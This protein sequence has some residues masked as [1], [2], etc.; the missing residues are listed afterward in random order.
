MISGERQKVM[1]KAAKW[2]CGLEGLVIIQYGVLV[3]RSGYTRQ[4]SGIKGIISKVMKSFICR[5]GDCLNPVTS[6]GAGI[7]SATDSLSADTAEHIGMV[8]VAENFRTAGVTEQ[9]TTMVR[10]VRTLGHAG[11]HES[12]AASTTHYSSVTTI[13]G[14]TGA[15]VHS[16]GHNLTSSSHTGR[17]GSSQQ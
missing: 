13:R 5:P 15:C 11:H 8:S 9:Q 14:H 10:V 6:T 4:C 3:V 17:P 1:Q 2:P 7:G 12:H 16:Y